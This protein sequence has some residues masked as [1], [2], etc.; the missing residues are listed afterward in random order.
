M[1]VYIVAWILFILLMGGCYYPK[2]R[3]EQTVESTGWEY[4]ELPS[5]VKFIVPHSPPGKGIFVYS[6]LEH[7]SNLE[8]GG[9]DEPYENSI[10]LGLELCLCP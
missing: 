10:K 5:S 2:V 8:E 4:T 1:W 7:A 9:Q 6:V 3:V